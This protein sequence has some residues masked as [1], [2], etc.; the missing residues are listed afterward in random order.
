M[1]NH[2]IPGVPGDRPRTGQEGPGPSRRVLLVDD[3]PFFLN[4][5]RHILRPAGYE[6]QTAASG[7]EA[8]DLA[9]TTRFDL[10][11]LDV[12]MPGMDGFETLRRLKANAATTGIPVAMLT[13][14]LDPKLNQ[15]AFQGGAEATIL[16]S[17]SAA[18]LLNMLQVILT[19]EK[20]AEPATGSDPRKSIL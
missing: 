12:E 3:Q 15:K 4:M 11:L 6:V 19:T 9:R 10:I 14:T 2:Q 17:L 13:A 20:A 16:K 7:A 18:R 1:E 5:A 8:L